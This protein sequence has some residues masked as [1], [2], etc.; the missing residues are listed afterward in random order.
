MIPTQEKIAPAQLADLAR[1]LR[2]AEGMDA[3]LAALHAGH[4]GTIGGGWGSASALAVATLASDVPGTLL[5]VLAHPGDLDTWSADLASFTGHAP[6]VFPAW[7]HL[8]TEHALNDEVLAQ[9]LRLLKA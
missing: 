7:D 8:P 4:G 1:V 5:V 2:A 6:L 9:R 3:V